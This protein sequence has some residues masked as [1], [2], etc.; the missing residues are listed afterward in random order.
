MENI[1]RLTSCLPLAP[2][3]EHWRG[4]H[5]SVSSADPGWDCQ[6]AS[7][8]W[9]HGWGPGHGRWGELGPSWDP[10]WQPPAFRVEW[11]HSHSHSH[12]LRR[13]RH[14]NRIATDITLPQS[15]KGDV[16]SKDRGLRMSCV[17]SSMLCS[18]KWCQCCDVSLYLTIFLVTAGQSLATPVCV[19][20]PCT[21]MYTHYH[22]GLEMLPGHK[23]HGPS[24]MT[25]AVDD[26]YG[27]FS[28]FKVNRTTPKV[29]TFRC[30]MLK[31]RSIQVVKC[32]N[33]L[34]V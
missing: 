34:A 25:T 26:I 18:P 9:S 21:T 22:E 24:M 5:W 12:Y 32:T 17:E 23:G 16:L 13:W 20:H 1:P 19:H 27:P 8:S 6:T 31:L 11:Q 14:E 30:Q 33:L 28:L 2:D 29:C 4:R 7:W 15:S 3:L 10:V